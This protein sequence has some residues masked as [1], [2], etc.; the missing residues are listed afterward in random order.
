[1]VW[2]RVSWRRRLGARESLA[3]FRAK[4]VSVTHVAGRRRREFRADRRN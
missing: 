4:A 2:L 3:Y 1:M